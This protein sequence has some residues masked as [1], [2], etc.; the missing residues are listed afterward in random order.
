MAEQNSKLQFGV[1]SLVGKPRTS[2]Q[3]RALA[4]RWM[5]AVKDDPRQAEHLLAGTLDACSALQIKI[6]I[7]TAALQVT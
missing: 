2:R 6:D 3:N 4:K 1:R 7:L 5:V